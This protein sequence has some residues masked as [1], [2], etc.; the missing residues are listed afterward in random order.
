MYN[1]EYMKKLGVSGIFVV[2]ARE[3]ITDYSIL[4]KCNKV[5]WQIGN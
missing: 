4:H 3:T 2:N 5:V 1:I